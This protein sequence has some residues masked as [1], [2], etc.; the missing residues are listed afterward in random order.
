M[1]MKQK[2]KMVSIII[3]KIGHS[4]IKEFV[5]FVIKMSQ[6]IMKMFHGQCL[7]RPTHLAR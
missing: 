5:L 1:V 7:L 4:V 6:I 3:Y 2:L